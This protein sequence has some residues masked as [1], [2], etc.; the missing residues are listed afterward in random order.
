MKV[1]ISSKNV[2]SS[3]HLKSA[4]E[5]KL[6]KL[7]KFFSEDVTAN[8]MVSEQR[9][10]QKLEVTIS[11]GGTL[12]RAEN[13]ADVAY[14]AIEGVVDKLTTQISKF[15]KK[16]QRK[17]KDNK[18]V[19]FDQIPE[20]VEEDTEGT[21]VR[22]KDIELT[23]MNEEEAVLQMELLGHSFFVFL[24]MENDA[25]SVVYKRKQGDYGIINAVK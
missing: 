23:P 6:E 7:D 22:R 11:A 5:K 2:K 3:E 14:D 10:K 20:L 9:D 21:I 13:T 4:I 8:V 18:V 17:H 16:L 24:N 15:K 25:V 12:F 1:I 19:V